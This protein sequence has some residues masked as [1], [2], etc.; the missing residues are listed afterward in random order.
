M[1][2][3]AITE[4]LT[5]PV[6][7]EYDVIVAGGG[8]SGLIAA[9]AAARCGARTAVVERAGCLGGTG[10]SGMVAQWIGLFNGSVRCVGGIGFELTQ[11]VQAA[12]GSEG[13]RRYT[14]AEASANPVTITNFP[15]NPE[16]VKIVAD[17]MASE[18]G[19]D[20]YLHSRVV[21]ALV[22]GRRVQGLVVENVGGRG[23][24]R[25]AML[26]DATGDA[27]VASA[28]G[29][30]CVGE[31]PELQHKRQPCTLVFRMSNVDVR[32]FRAMPREQKRAI[33]LEG[34]KEGRLAWESL[35][36][37]STPGELDAV[38]LMSRIHGIDA[39]DP[40][41]LTR[42]EQTGRQQIKSIVS[43]LQERVPGFERS[44][45]GGI[46]ERV[47]I[48]ETR[49]IVGR[50]T[51]TTEDIVGGRRFADAVA[52]G[53][54][55]M[56]LHEA[57]GTGVD[58]WMPPAPFEIPLACQLPQEMEGLVVTGR[59]ISA[60]RE[61]NG[62]A[63]HMGTAM[64]LGHAAGVYAALA[65]RGEASLQEPAPEKV[66]QVLRNQKA[67]VSSDDAMAAAANDTPIV[68]RAA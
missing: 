65:S 19:V 23:A 48:R 68:A 49:R 35:S 41:D 16:V 59:A 39:L 4:T 30:P 55:P 24:L 18:A 62:G 57:G 52:L 8:A 36:F 10:T 20:V 38:C 63:R 42:A 3:P 61:A 14:L 67:L 15:F 53:A 33:A 12:G 6:L 2:R 1:D 47:G 40:R 11:R 64:C 21:R 9:V 27:V 17:E 56:D 22:E 25:S 34:L 32:T 51:L 54:G 44:L 26:V 60:T 43:F 45:L 29:V 13:F 5:T 66:R 37:C 31:E 46:A 58:L 50:H 28:A 7:G